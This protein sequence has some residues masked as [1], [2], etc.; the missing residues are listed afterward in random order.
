MKF[1]FWTGASWLAMFIVGANVALMYA[2]DTYEPSWW[3]IGVFVALAFFFHA[4][5]QDRR[6]P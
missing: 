2:R 1:I 3:R 6:V 4:T 5:A